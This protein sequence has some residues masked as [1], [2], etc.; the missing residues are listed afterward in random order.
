MPEDEIIELSDSS[1]ESEKEGPMKHW[2]TEVNEV[3]DQ[4]ATLLGKRYHSV[5]Y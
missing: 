1:S 5:L 2:H 4:L 3:M